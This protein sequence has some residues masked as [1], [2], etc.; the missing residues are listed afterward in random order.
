MDKKFH[1]ASYS[2]LESGRTKKERKRLDALRHFI[3]DMLLEY[4]EKWEKS[5]MHDPEM[6]AA[7]RPYVKAE[8]WD[9]LQHGALIE[10]WS[11][12]HRR[13]NTTGYSRGT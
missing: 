7:W 8:K 9:G 12:V 13:R 2:F 5:A 4:L 11:N 6:T 10:S 3:R 1:V